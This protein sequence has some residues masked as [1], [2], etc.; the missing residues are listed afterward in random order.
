MHPFS[1]SYLFECNILMRYKD[2]WVDHWMALD[3][4]FEAM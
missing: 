2:I 1:S 3:E 4:E